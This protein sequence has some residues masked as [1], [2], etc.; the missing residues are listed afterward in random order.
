MHTAYVQLKDEGYLEGVAGSGTYVSRRL[1]ATLPPTRPGRTGGRPAPDRAR[2][3]ASRRG[4]RQATAYPE[5]ARRLPRLDETFK[6]GAP[7]L[8]RF[9]HRLWHKTLTRAWH[10]MQDRNLLGSRGDYAPLQEAVARHLGT[11]RGV[12]CTA[13]QVLILAGSQQ[14]IDLSLRVLLDPGQR[15]LIEDPCYPGARGAMLGAGIAPVPLAV[16]AEGL[17]LPR[18]TAAC[19]AY[20]T[21]SHQYPLGAT[22]SL[23]RRLE[24]LDWARTRRAWILEDDYHSEYRYRGRPLASLQGLDADGR[25]LYL[26]TFSKILFPAL[27]LAYLVVPDDLVDLFNAARHL[28]GHQPPLLEQI[29]LAAFIKEGHLA[30]HLRRMGRLYSERQQA[31]AEAAAQLGDALR[32]QTT[33]AG[34]HAIGWLAPKADDQAV[35]RRAADAGLYLSPL[36]D[37][38]IK[39]RQA[40]ALV[41]GYAAADEKRIRRGVNRLARVLG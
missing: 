15:A 8:D 10:T 4:L 36:S 32:L 1:P 35:A 16:D 40:P 12:R 27:R 28:S 38:V 30:R 33:Q 39:K 3:T 21:P 9:P 2:R 14:G 31:L 24:V 22:M 13:G 18:R 26:G 41:L 19:F 11:T 6:P 7:A 20:T 25:V 34:L 17:R 37:Y 23:R 5:R 29:A